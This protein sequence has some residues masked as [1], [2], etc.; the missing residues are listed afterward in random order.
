MLRESFVL[1]PPGDRLMA[2]QVR[3]GEIRNVPLG[4][5]WGKL[6]EGT[7]FSGRLFFGK[8]R[9]YGLFTQL[10]LPD[11]ETLPVCVEL[12]QEKPG[13]QILPRSTSRNVWISASAGVKAVY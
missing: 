8:D 6:R 12:V 4:Y 3:E 9:V 10:H 7:L 11:G 2:I 5:K 13:T 1:I